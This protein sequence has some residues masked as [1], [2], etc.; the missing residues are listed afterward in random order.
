MNT[1]LSYVEVDLD[2]IAHNIRSLKHHIG[3]DV[4]LMAVVKANAYGHG[5]IQVSDTALAHG[6]DWLAVART[7]EGVQLRQAGIRAPVLVMNY[8]GRNDIETA[9][10]HNLV[11]TVTEWGA[12][13]HIST[14][15]VQN[16]KTVLVHVKVDTGMG[17][18]G[19]LPDEVLPFV[20]RVAALPGIVI[21][22]IFSHFSVSDQADKAY[23][24]QQYHT[25]ERVLVDLETAGHTIPVRHIANSAAT[26]DLPSTYLDA[27]RVGITTYGLK[28]SNEVTPV[29]P[30][31][32]ALSLKSHVAR[33]RTLPAGSSIS[34]GRTFVTPHAM[35]VALVP[36]GYGDGYHRLL[37]N[38]GAVLINGQRAPIVGRVCMDQFVVDVS[39]VGPVNVDDDVVL[40][41]QQG[42]GRISA[43]D[44]A[45]WANTINYEVTTGLLPRLPRLYRA[46]GE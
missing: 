6:A 37:S 12:A 14:L 27:V 1:P 30:L 46:S 43:E 17:R 45:G 10:A 3:H 33:V 9:V 11:I 39:D 20:S 42:E 4:S 16:N 26:L 21:N 24:Q 8:V 23:T 19:L 34:Y 13:E 7:S 25:F 40:I 22:G 44:V 38:R 32:P 36:V 2:A 35:L 15:A 28:P 31:R 18:F 29:V 5:A 41:G